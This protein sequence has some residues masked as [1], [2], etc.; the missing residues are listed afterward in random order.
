[1]K[2]IC[3]G[4]NP[5]ET[6]KIGDKAGMVLMA[7]SCVIENRDI[8]FR[9]AEYLKKLTNKLNIGYIFKASFDKANRTSISSFRGPGLQE[10]LDILS[11]V[12]A[13]FKVPVISDIHLPDQAPAAAEV[14][15]ILQIPAFLARQTDL[16]V[17]AAKTKK[18]VQVKKPQF[19]A[20]WDMK[21][22]VTKITEQ[23]NNQIILVER[24]SSFGYNRLICDMMSIPQMQE[25]GYPAIIDATH[26]TQQPGGLGATS[27]GSPEFA[28]T[29][30]RAAIA[31]G[32]DGLF[33]E[34]HPNPK[35]ALSDAA[36]MLP[37]DKLE[38]LL[39]TCRDIFDRLR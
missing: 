11:Q 3:I 32:A 33:L 10:G 35:E 13:E 30:A 24:G 19:L 25:L 16:V 29:L 6:V 20:P 1:M 36:S 22:V 26:S 15:D 34:T 28:H 21:N 12:K 7:G 31:A 5:V 37:L 27:G 2:T 18:C 9:I 17:A 23:G 4:T 39:T 14:L 38:K 8:C